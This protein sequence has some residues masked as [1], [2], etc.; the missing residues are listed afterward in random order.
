MPERTAA[1]AAAIPAMSAPQEPLRTPIALW[2][3]P[4]IQWRAGKIHLMM[5]ETHQ[6]PRWH[7]A[8]MDFG[9]FWMFLKCRLCDPDRRSQRTS[10]QQRVCVGDSAK[11]RTSRIGA[12]AVIRSWLGMGLPNGRNLRTRRTRGWKTRDFGDVFFP[13]QFFGIGFGFSC[14][15]VGCLITSSFCCLVCVCVAD[16]NL[17]DFRIPLCKDDGPFFGATRAAGLACC[18][19]R[20]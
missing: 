13:V 1:A 12:M 3:P 11:P 9:G 20:L 15:F 14:Y 17:S 8:L 2:N 5:L 18:L 16:L 7:G 19:Q 6:K 4:K 10:R